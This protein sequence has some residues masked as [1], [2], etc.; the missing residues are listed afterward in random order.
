MDKNLNCSYK[1]KRIEM[2]KLMNLSKLFKDFFKLFIP[3]K[4]LNCG[5]SLH[6]YEHY[7]CKGCLMKIAKT[8]FYKDKDNPV[9]QLFWGRVKLEH[10]FSFYYFSKGSNIQRLIH[11]V[12]YHGGKEL[13]LELGKEFGLEIKGSSF[14]S[15]IDVICPVP[16]H[17]QKEK[18]RGYNQSEWIARGLSEVL[19]IP[20]EKYLLKRMVY[21]STQTKKSRQQRWENVKDAFEVGDVQKT[22]DKHVLIVDDVLTTGATLEACAQKL[23]EIEGTKVSIVTLAYAYDL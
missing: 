12:K 9:S 21:T 6:D 15:E 17:E 2:S 7:V 11:E 4:C 14:C 16:L 18:R 1:T 22:A 20:I 5:L 8:N 3:S 13:A 19:N 23:L 10:A